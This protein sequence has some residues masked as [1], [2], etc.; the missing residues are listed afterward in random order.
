MSILQSLNTYWSGN[1]TLTGA[2]PTASVY[3]DLVP[4][5]VA[6]PYVRLTIISN[7]PTHTTGSADIRECRL[8]LSIFSPDLNGLATIANTIDSQFDKATGLFSGFMACLQ[9]NRI[10]QAENLA[11]Q[12]VYHEMLEYWIQYNSTVG[13]S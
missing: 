9:E 6:F 13:T 10:Q 4:P 1:A 2:I 11:G 12:T 8:Q 7:Q 3:L 5:N